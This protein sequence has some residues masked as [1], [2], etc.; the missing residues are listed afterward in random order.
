MPSFFQNKYV[1]FALI[2]VAGVVGILVL[3]F[4]WGLVNLTA[5]STGL[6]SSEIAFAPDMGANRG[7]AESV[8]G[9]DMTSSYMPPPQPGSGYTSDL[10]LYETTDYSVSARTQEFD[11]FCNLLATLK[12]DTRFD[13][14]NLYSS[15]NSCS[16]TFFTSE[17]NVPAVLQQL[18][19]F[20]GVQI[21]RSTN[22]V[23]RHREQL[24]SRTGIVRQQLASVERSLA[25]AETE[26]D[27][28]ARFAREQNDATTLAQAIREKLNLIDSLTQRRINLTS[29][30]DSLYQQAADL[31]ERL[32]VVQFS[33]S[34]QRSYPKNPDETTRAWERAWEQLSDTYTDTLIGLTAFFGVF[35]LWAV[36]ITL[37]L[38]V[39]L[40]IVRGLWK[41]V[42]LIWKW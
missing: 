32:G 9:Y 12:A 38:V 7:M 39:V 6:Q 37:Y 4:I 35:L 17:T 20:D 34:I 22:S 41:F 40:L 10:E 14:R 29:Q 25:V 42:R 26:F 21:T 13:F 1:K 5:T 27:E 23:T 2:G 30:L 36:R 18:N 33:V 28:I 15:L 11:A 3:L 16:A 24:Q 31:E 19:G 8:A